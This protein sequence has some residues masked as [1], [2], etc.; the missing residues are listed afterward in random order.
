MIDACT[1][2][3][4]VGTL[5]AGVENICVDYMTEKGIMVIHNAGRNAEAVSDFTI[6]MMLAEYRNIARS[7]AAVKAGGGARTMSTSPTA[8]T[9][10]A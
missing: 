5:R 2:L 3:K 6:G 1:K 9:S 10:K 8:P 4:A 7:H